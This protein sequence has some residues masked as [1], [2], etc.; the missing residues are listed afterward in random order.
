MPQNSLNTIRINLSRKQMDYFAQAAELGGFKSLADFFLTA[1]SK[2][3]EVIMGKRN[4]WL[5]SETDRKIFFNALIN[6]PT[7]N[8]RLTQA[9]KRHNEF[10][11]KKY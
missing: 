1:A 5:S 7:P 3:A 4:A 6:P 8:V 11:P 2:K 10:N 9:M